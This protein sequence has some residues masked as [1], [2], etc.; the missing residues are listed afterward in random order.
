MKR[1]KETAVNLPNNQTAGYSLHMETM[2]AVLIDEDQRL[3][4]AFAAALLKHPQTLE[5]RFAAALS[6]TGDTG[7]ALLMANKWVD[8]PSVI[9]EVDRLTKRGDEGDLN[10][11]GSK[12]DFAREVLEAGR[13][14]WD[15]DT[16]HKFFKLYAEVRGFIS[17]DGG[18]NVNVQVNNNKVMIV[19][20]LG[21]DAEWEAKAAQ[22][23]RALIDVSASR[24]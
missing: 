11:I 1:G 22:Q 5:G 7:K 6:C 20:D 18:T 17:K 10:F 24:H 23:Q 15:G 3:K 21:T 13:N 14:S 9:S 4:L 2:P 12:A 8:D 19:R 16:K